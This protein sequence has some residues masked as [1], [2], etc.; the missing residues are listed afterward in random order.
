MDRPYNAE[1]AAKLAA[2]AANMLARKLSKATR[3]GSAVTMSRKD[4]RS[5]L[6]ALRRAASQTDSGRRIMAHGEAERAAER[7]ARY[8][9]IE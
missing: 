8:E 2:L 5:L 6:S 7:D 4:I 3:A 9:A 1:D